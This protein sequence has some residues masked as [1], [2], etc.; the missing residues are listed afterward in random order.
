ME[1]D[2]NLRRFHEL[3]RTSRYRIR[4]ALA[5]RQIDDSS[6]SD[7]EIDRPNDQAGAPIRLC[8]TFVYCEFG[9]N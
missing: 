4:K 8:Q 7:E 9:F 5:A 3:S 2:G 1:R 6:T